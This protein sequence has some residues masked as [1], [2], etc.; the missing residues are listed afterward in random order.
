MTM[1]TNSDPKYVICVKN[2]DYRASLIVRKIYRVILD[3]A[4]RANGLLRVVDESGEDYLFPEDF[5]VSVSVSK[6]AKKIIAKAS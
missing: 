2:K 5:F 1:A 3:R 4:A 6:Q